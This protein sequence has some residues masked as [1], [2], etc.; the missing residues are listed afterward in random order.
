MDIIKDAWIEYKKRQ[1]LKVLKDGK[2][3]IRPLSKSTD[4]SGTRAEVVKLH[5]VM[6]FPKYLEKYGS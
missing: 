5:T 4:L 3:E 6:S 1:V 2:W